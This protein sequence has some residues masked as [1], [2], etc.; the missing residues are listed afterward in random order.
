[1]TER[2]ET[3]PTRPSRLLVAGL[4]LGGVAG[5]GGVVAMLLIAIE[6]VRTGHGLDM[7]RTHWLVE[8]NWIG[9]LIFMA[10]IALALAVGVFFWWK[11]RREVQALLRKYSEDRHG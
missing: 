3:S 7:Y 1:M 11:E 4:W 10:A 6:K 9:F 8:F 5:V 2:D